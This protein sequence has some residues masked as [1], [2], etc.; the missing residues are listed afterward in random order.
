[1][2]KFL[3]QKFQAVWSFEYGRD[4]NIHKFPKNSP[5]SIR[6]NSTSDYSKKD[7]YSTD[8]ND[9]NLIYVEKSFRILSIF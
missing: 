2:R 9:L 4:D 6:V 7:C 1:M 3:L 8:D 5:T